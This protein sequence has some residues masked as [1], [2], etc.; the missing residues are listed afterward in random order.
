MYKDKTKYAEKILEKIKN[1]KWKKYIAKPIFGQESKDFKKFNTMKKLPLVAYLTKNLNKYPGVCIQ[2]YIEGFDK[3]NPE[4]R[5]YFVGDRYK[6]SII[7]TEKN[8]WE[9]SEKKCDPKCPR[10]LRKIQKSGIT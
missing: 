4:I 3:E 1:N 9:L 5:M 7:T 10:G 2:E 8:V 6:Y